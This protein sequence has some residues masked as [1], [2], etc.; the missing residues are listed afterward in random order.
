[1]FYNG[2]PLKA[3]QPGFGTPAAAE[4]EA[5]KEATGMIHGSFHGQQQVTA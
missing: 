4:S 2:S 5:V 1:M 3:R